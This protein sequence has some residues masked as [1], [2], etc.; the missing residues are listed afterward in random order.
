MNNIMILDHH[1]LFIYINSGYALK[2]YHDVSIVHHLAVYREWREY[3]IHWN[4]YFKY[5]LVDPRYLGEEIFI[6]RRMGR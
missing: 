6:M 4:D 1:G 2:S 5:F 3:F